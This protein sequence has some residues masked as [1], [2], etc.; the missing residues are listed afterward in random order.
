MYFIIFIIDTYSSLC[1]Y[2]SLNT[3][4]KEKVYLQKYC[5]PITLVELIVTAA[6][7]LF[8]TINGNNSAGNGILI[9]S[10]LSLK[11]YFSLSSG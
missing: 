7:A 3:S 9:S 5:A 8:E 1:E 6:I 2:I 11:S 10:T 4:A